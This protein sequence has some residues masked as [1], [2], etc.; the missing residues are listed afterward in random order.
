MTYE[1]LIRK[2]RDGFEA[3]TEIVLEGVKTKG[4]GGTSFNR[5]GKSV[6]TISTGKSSFNKGLR[7]FASASFHGDD[8]TITTVLFGDY[9]KTLAKNFERCTEKTVTKL[10]AEVLVMVP[11]ILEEVTAFYAPKE[12]ATA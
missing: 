2:G 1:T 6:L 5:P 11:A 8:G 12:V 4:E 3:K 9:S 10:H 7:S